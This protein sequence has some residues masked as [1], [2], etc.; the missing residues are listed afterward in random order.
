MV[1]VVVDEL[2]EAE[3]ARDGVLLPVVNV[4]VA[5]VTHNPEVCNLVGR[6]HGQGEVA[7]AH[8]KDERP[9]RRPAA[10]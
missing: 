1:S 10:V 3:E 4:D 9:G 5:P 8:P 6:A 7:A 2:V